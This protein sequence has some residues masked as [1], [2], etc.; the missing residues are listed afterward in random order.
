MFITPRFRLCSFLRADRGIGVPAVKFQ[1]ALVR[2]PLARVGPQM[3][4]LAPVLEFAS[5]IHNAARH[6]TGERRPASRQAYRL[7]AQAETLRQ[8][9][10]STQGLSRNT[11]TYSAVFTRES[12]RSAYQK[13]QDK[14]IS[15]LKVGEQ[16]AVAIKVQSGMGTVFKAVTQQA[17]A[18]QFV[19][20]CL[21]IACDPTGPH[22]ADAPRRRNK[23]P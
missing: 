10:V 22:G 13:P 16:R 1:H 8:L 14:A 2:E 19:F 21:P 20:G 11:Y 5:G 4:P 6:K 18:E 7:I 17:T 12:S 15:R 3:D 23:Q 9:I